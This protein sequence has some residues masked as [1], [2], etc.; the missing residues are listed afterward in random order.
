MNRHSMLQP[1]LLMPPR[2]FMM[3]LLIQPGDAEEAVAAAT[4]C[5]HNDREE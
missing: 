5:Y 3:A 2:Y 1:L 4:S